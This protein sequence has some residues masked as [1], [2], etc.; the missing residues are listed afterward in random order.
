[1]EPGIGVQPLWMALHESAYVR[2]QL[3]LLATFV[4]AAGAS[5]MLL[6]DEAEEL[7][8]AAAVGLNAKRLTGEGDYGQALR[9]PLSADLGI[10]SIAAFYGR[11]I[12]LEKMDSRHNKSVDERLDQR[13]ESICAMP[14]VL[15][16][17]V[18]GTLSVINAHAQGA[19]D[20][21]NRFRRE[22]Q[23]AAQQVAQALSHWLRDATTTAGGSY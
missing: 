18:M 3:K 1:M 20:V 13:T 16:T 15:E 11:M 8:F 12:C 6:D 7:V 2:W 5:V 23:E 10:N 14:L 9:I 17:G 21:R 22:D 4:E 19:P